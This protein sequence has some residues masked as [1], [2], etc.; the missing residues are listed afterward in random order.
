MH[1]RQFVYPTCPAKRSATGRVRLSESRSTTDA[2]GPSRSI[3]LP[4]KLP[5]SGRRG[6]RWLAAAEAEGG[7]QLAGL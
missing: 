5:S 3:P 7:V 4:R 6:G 2:E 1:A